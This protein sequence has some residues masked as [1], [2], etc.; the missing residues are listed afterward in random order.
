M[1]F[2]FGSPSAVALLTLAVLVAAA[3]GS[4][5]VPKWKSERVPEVDERGWVPDQ[6]GLFG[7]RRPPAAPPAS[8]GEI[9]YAPGTEVAPGVTGVLEYDRE[10]AF[11][12]LN[13]MCSGDVAAAELASMTGEVLHRWAFPYRR[14]PDAPE[15]E[16]PHQT[17]WRRVHLLEDG[18]LLAIH[19]GRALVCVDV[20]SNLRWVSFERAHHDLDV[21]PDGTIHAL[22]RRERVVPAIDENRPLVDDFVLLLNASGDAVARVSL[23]DAFGRSRWAFMLDHL[24][25]RQGDV[26]H[27]NSIRRIDAETAARLGLE[28]VEAGQVLV[29]M[30]DLDLVVTVDLDAKVLTWLT[31]GPSGDG[32]RAP[33]D[34]TIT[35]QGDLL[36]FDN[37]G[38][39]GETSRLLRMDPETREVAWSWRGSPPESFASFFCGTARQLPNG[40]VLATES[41]QGRAIE[42]DAET[43]EIVWEFVSDR[44]TG[45]DDSYVAAL[46][47]VQRVTRPGWLER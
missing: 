9:G 24:T 19:S 28:G 36:I 34:P 16:G 1:T 5:D 42:L 38:G 30:R 14:L 23:W 46:F 45:P 15:L 8:I 25:V 18:S 27:A 41:T 43:G 21:A 17:P 39:P 10:R 4:E 13:L 35:A 20:A 22:A 37:R 2:P 26:M 11:D 40:N 6:P 47:E 7:F 33:H 3:C 32:W 31:Q 44:V 29:C 12:G